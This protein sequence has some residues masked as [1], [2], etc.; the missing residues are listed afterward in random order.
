MKNSDSF[1]I[2]SFNKT[3]TYKLLLKQAFALTTKLPEHNKCLI[4]DYLVLAN[5][6]EAYQLSYELRFNMLDVI[7]N[8]IE[9][10]FKQSLAQIKLPSE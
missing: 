10:F 4:E 5:F 9:K 8:E 6:V 2:E 1:K 3:E 7:L